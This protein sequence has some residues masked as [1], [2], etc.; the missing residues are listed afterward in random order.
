MEVTM[1]KVFMT[2]MIATAAFLFVSMDKEANGIQPTI[3]TAHAM[4]MIQNQAYPMGGPAPTCM[5]LGAD[6][7][8]KPCCDNLKCRTNGKGD[9]SCGL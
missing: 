7:T 5:K 3:S 6:C 2:V 1:K 4:E 9:S 8:F